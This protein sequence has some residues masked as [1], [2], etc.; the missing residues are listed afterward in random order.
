MINLYLNEYPIED[1]IAQAGD[2]IIKRPIKGKAIMERNK[3]WSVEIEFPEADMLGYSM[4]DEAY[5]KVD[6]THA[7]DQLF[8]VV[9]WKYN[10][11]KRTY[12]VYAVDIFH[13]SQKEVLV[14]DREFTQVSTWGKAIETLNELITNSNPK[15]SYILKGSQGY[16]NT[17]QPDMLH[18]YLLVPKYDQTKAIDVLFQRMYAGAHVVFHPMNRTL[19]QRFYITPAV[20][21]DG[22]YQIWNEKS[23]MCLDVMNGVQSESTVSQSAYHAGDNQR[24]KIVPSEFVDGH[25]CIV[26][27]LNENYYL[28]ATSAE[29]PYYHDDGVTL[30]AWL[31]GL[32]IDTKAT[33]AGDK[34]N[35]QA[36]QFWRSESVTLAHWEQLNLI[37]I[38]FGTTDYSLVSK[39]EECEEHHVTAMYN[40]LT[41][42]F[43]GDYAEDWCKPHEYYISSPRLVT[44]QEK[45]VSMEDVYTGIVPIGAN[46][47]MLPTDY[48]GTINGVVVLG[49]SDTVED[50]YDVYRFH[51]VKF[52]EYPEIIWTEDQQDA[53]LSEYDVYESEEYL[54]RAL[55]NRAKKDLK[56]VEVRKPN[57]DLE[58]KIAYILDN[59]ELTS[60]LKLSDRI[61]FTGNVSD[62]VEGFYLD[63]I[64]YDLV[65]KRITDVTLS[66][67]K[68]DI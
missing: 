58:I 9:Y 1:M 25:W 15:K 36:F 57:T 33:S 53:D 64:E 6:L 39:W 67:I 2:V 44:T 68:E 46:N 3:E 10:R 43:G 29:H 65:T 19:A 61:Y 63:K 22:W 49:D 17:A 66:E 38:L 40:N 7:D 28:T 59:E 62:E 26:S 41:C 45:K 20:G 32:C 12:T 34:A 27:A 24:W 42:Y 56:K 54:R 4:V 37:E 55:F 14:T 5:V 31:R 18:T 47:R 52:E 21:Y 50:L 23:I 60:K 48:S 11:K 30:A 51:R 16:D 8:S 13:L 35:R